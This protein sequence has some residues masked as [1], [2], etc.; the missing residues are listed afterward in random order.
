MSTPTIDDIQ[1]AFMLLD[2]ETSRMICKEMRQPE[3]LCD[4]CADDRGN[5]VDFY[6]RD[7][8]IAELDREAFWDGKHD[9]NVFRRLSTR[10]NENFTKWLI[11]H[12]YAY[13]I[14]ETPEDKP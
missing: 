6:D 12:D 14:T 5:V 1:H 10:A 11:D 3:T 7:G 9:Q 4:Y 13:V 8:Q 2:L